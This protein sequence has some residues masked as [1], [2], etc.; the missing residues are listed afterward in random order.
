VKKVT[1]RQATLHF[2]KFAKLASAG[3]TIIVTDAGQP[4]VLLQPPVKTKSP[5]RKLKWPDFPAHWRG[6]FPDGFVQGPTATELLAEDKEDR[7]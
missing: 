5:R 4:W 2:E 6:H 7:F 1:R 3:E